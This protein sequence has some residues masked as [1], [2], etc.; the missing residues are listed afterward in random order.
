MSPSWISLSRTRVNNKLEKLFTL[1]DTGKLN[2]LEIE[3]IERG[4]KAVAFT[5]TTRRYNRTKAA[6]PDEYR[7]MPLVQL[8]LEKLILKGAMK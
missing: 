8:L 2:L 7:K 5:K 3:P 1:S 4:D 6:T